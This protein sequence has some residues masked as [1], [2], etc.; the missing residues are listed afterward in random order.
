MTVSHIIMHFVD[1]VKNDNLGQIS[2]WLLANADDKGIKCSECEQLARMHSTAV[3]F[4]KTGVPAE[5]QAMKDL[6]SSS[7]VS[8]VVMCTRGGGETTHWL[9]AVSLKAR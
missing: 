9:G 5:H 4:A 2:T 1:H 6:V 7:R 8:P 3:D